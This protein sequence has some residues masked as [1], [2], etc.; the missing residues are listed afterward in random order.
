[1]NLKKIAG[2]LLFFAALVV[3]WQ[4]LYTAAC[5]W[6]SWAKPYAIPSPAGVLDCL[7]RLASNGTLW[8]AITSSLIRVLIGFVI[9]IAI[10]I[11]LGALIV[12]FRYLEQNLKPLIL[13]VQ[14]LPS[15]C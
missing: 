11:V 9:S 5:D 2:N 8:A 7:A 14:T 15:I 6:F 13:G 1:M 3:M 12:R 4:L 10:G